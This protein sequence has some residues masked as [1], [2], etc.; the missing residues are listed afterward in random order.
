[1][2][3]PLIMEF[4]RLKYLTLEGNIFNIAEKGCDCGSFYEYKSPCAHAIAAATYR[5]EDPLTFFYD[6][7]STRACRKTYSHPLRPISIDDLVVDENI[8]PP[9]I[10]KQAG[11][12]GTGRIRKG[13]WERTQTQCSCCLDWG[14]NKRPCRGQ[15]VSYGRRGHARDWPVEVVN[16]EL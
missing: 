10:R 14:H 7:Y 3:S 11:R 8:K 13:A 6:A 5:S 16:R 15:P 1:M 4:I 2:V 9:I 12:P